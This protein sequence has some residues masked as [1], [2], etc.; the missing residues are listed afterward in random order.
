M[1]LCFIG[2][3]GFM[4]QA[5]GQFYQNLDNVNIDVWGRVEPFYQF[6]NFTYIDLLDTSIPLERLC[7]YD[8]IF[9]FAGDG[10]Q[11][12]QLIVSQ[13]IYK[14]NTFFPIELAIALNKHFYKGIFVTFGSY[15]EIGSNSVE[16]SFD[17][18]AII[19]SSLP[20]PNDYTVSKR[21]LSK[22]ID[23]YPSN[24]KLLHFIIP[25]IYG[26]GENENRLI[27]Y[28]LKCKREGKKIKLTAGSQVR[29]YLAVQELPLIVH[30]AITMNILSGIYNVG[31]ADTLSIKELVL[32][33]A[34]IFGIKSNEIE[35]NTLQKWDTGMHYLSLDSR[36]L[37]NAI[38][39][40]AQYQLPVN[41][42]KYL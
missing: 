33:A 3:N 28:L 19:N 25:T 11:S 14:I 36:K 40:K 41:I 29:E 17:E 5:F 7:Q 30:K 27:P 2:S 6:R 15:A 4:A 18:I 1:N 12:N 39:Y 26:V 21:L 8:V 32:F 42:K 34:D 23:T 16:K 22:F 13:N 20:V 9:Y 35:F 37:S 31:G 10:V 38:A 24:S